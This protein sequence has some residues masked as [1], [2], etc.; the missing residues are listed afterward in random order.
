MV[1]ARILNARLADLT[2]A[3]IST[4][5]NYITGLIASSTVFLILG[6]NEPIHSGFVLST[7]W[8]IYFGGTV[9]MVFVMICNM[10]V[11][12]I[13]SFSLSLF[14][15][16]GQVFAGIMIDWFISGEFSLVILL[17]GVLVTVGLVV[18]LVSGKKVS[19]VKIKE[20]D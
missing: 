17:G 19:R 13:S 20:T 4:F 5:Y 1:Y 12:K 14:Q 9:G 6:N 8:Y 10:I 11:T 7:D 2:N 16:V 3:R 15:F 18:D